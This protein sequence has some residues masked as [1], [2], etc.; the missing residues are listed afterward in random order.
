ME[1]NGRIADALA[2]A[3]PAQHDAGGDSR[4]ETVAALKHALAEAFRDLLQCPDAGA[5]TAAIRR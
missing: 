1:S 3:P 2:P 5:K 4:N